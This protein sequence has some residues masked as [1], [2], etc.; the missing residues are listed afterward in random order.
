MGL[1]VRRRSLVVCLL[2]AAVTAGCGGS[3]ATKAGDRDGPRH[4]TVLTMVIAEAAQTDHTVFLDAVKR[5]SHGTLRIRIVPGGPSSWSELPQQGTEV[6]AI[7][8]VEQ[9]QPAMA[10]LPSRVWQS[11]GVESFRALWAPF[12]IT[13]H[14]LLW[15]VVTSPVATEMLQATEVRGVTSLAIVPRD[16][17]RILGKTP[18]V[19]IAAF[20]GVRVATNSHDEAEVLRA[21]GAIPRLHEVY[22]PASLSERRIDAVEAGGPVIPMHGYT[23]LAP[24]VPANVVLFPRTDVISIN[25]RVFDGLTPEERSAL[26][27][28][29]RLAVQAQRDLAD[30]ETGIL[31][32]LCQLGGKLVVASGAQ[33]A[34]LRE[35]ERPVYNELARDPRVRPYLDQI[36]AMKR[37]TPPD[38]PL[39][40]P[41]G[42]AG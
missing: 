39:K 23:R 7:E 11:Q 12:L 36:E 17:R 33:L 40:I 29:A 20:R 14:A 13:S 38:P 5:L 10:W 25:K 31:R 2:V 42:C 22:P 18:L 30:Q 24:Y 16:L 1:A 32:G 28:G 4:T 34:Q 15:K 37:G 19:S 3:L 6:R 26:R 21:L 27:E 41:R 8:H 35:A 9:G